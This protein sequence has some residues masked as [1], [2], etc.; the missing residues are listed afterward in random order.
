MTMLIRT[1]APTI[2]ASILSPRNA[3]AV[4]AITRINTSG[5]ANACRRSER[6][7]WCCV[8][9]GSFGPNWSSRA[10]AS[11]AVKPAIAAG[12]SLTL[13]DMVSSL[14]REPAR[15]FKKTRAHGPK[16]GA[17][18]VRQVSHAT[19]LHLGHRAGV[20]ELSEEPEPNEKRGRDESDAHKHKEE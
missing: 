7:E 4:A 11:S 20:Q 2:P 8:A 15:V 6:K 5:F 16:D 14:V 19:R 17:T 1:M 18:N 3:E 12:V 10:C 13:E 9:A